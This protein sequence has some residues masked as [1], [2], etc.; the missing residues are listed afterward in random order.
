[1]DLQA[2]HSKS[3]K[4]H[5]D[6]CRLRMYMCYKT[7]DHPKWQSVRHLVEDE[8]AINRKSIDTDGAPQTPKPDLDAKLFEDPTEPDDFLDN[9]PDDMFEDPPARDLDPPPEAPRQDFAMEAD[10]AAVAD[11]FGDFDSDMGEAESAMVDSLKMAGVLPKHA[12]KKAKKI[13]QPTFIEAY[14]RTITDYTNQARRNLNVKGLSSLDFRTPKANGS[15]WDFRQRSDRHEA[16]KLI[17]DLDPDWVLGAPPCTAFSIWNYALN[18]KKMDADA[19]RE[20]LA[21]GRMHL[22]FCCRMYRREIRR[23]KF[24]LH[25]HPATAMS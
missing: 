16:L 10:E 23:G 11:V 15:P 18:Y 22:K 25:E 3:T 5:N 24:F 1:M 4:L 7:P 21:E 6:E 2:G 12:R 14:G 9:L 8:H 13:L 19:V 17:D 20:K